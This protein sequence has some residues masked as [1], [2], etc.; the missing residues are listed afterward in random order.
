MLNM[1]GGMFRP[2]GRKKE[3]EDE[4]WTTAAGGDLTEIWKVKENCIVCKTRVNSGE[5]GIKCDLCR[6]W[7]HADCQGVARKDYDLLSKVETKV[8]WFCVRCD[9]KMDDISDGFRKME[10]KVELVENEIIRIKKEEKEK[11]QTIDLL[12]EEIR[13]IKM[14]NVERWRNIR[15]D[16]EQMETTVRKE[17]QSAWE[18]NGKRMETYH[19]EAG[20][21]HESNLLALREEVEEMKKK[22]EESHESKQSKEERKQEI[23]LMKQEVVNKGV[24][25]IKK[26]WK[27]EEKVV[28]EISQKIEEI[29]KERK[30]KNLIMFNLP[31]SNEEEATKRYQ[32]DLSRCGKIFTKELEIQDLTLEKVIRIGKKKENGNRPLII[33][34]GSE[35]DRNTV[36]SKAKRLRYSVEFARV[37]LAKDMTEAEREKDRKLRQELIEKRKKKEDGWYIIRR[38]KVMKVQQEESKEEGAAGRQDF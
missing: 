24:E 10:Q 35:A 28:Q 34:L 12:V 9:G 22:K 33:K 4:Q 31:E 15:E 37:Y 30:K 20:K 14:E 6:R 8:M 32:E 1:P 36:L 11:Q 23:E 16:F 5:R 21:R 3:G 29:D 25:E 27:N 26:S 17:S 2:A 7:Y 18:E 19:R 13:K 38:G